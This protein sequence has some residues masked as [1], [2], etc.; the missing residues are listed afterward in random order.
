MTFHFN[1]FNNFSVIRNEDINRY[2]D[3][4]TRKNKDKKNYKS[5]INRK[6]TL[7]CGTSFFS[8]VGEKSI[9]QFYF[10]RKHLRLYLV[11]HFSDNFS[12]TFLLSSRCNG[13]LIII[14]HPRVYNTLK[15]SIIKQLRLRSL[16]FYRLRTSNKIYLTKERESQFILTPL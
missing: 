13:Y 10:P 16:S 1:P 11:H 3:R 7:L 5:F 15:E 9:T 12:V 2:T 14:N 4:L 8:S 6:S